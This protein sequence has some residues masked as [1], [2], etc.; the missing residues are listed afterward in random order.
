M[1]LE[2]VD[3]SWC[4]VMLNIFSCAYWPSICLFVCL[5]WK[6]IQVLCSFL[7]WVVCLVIELL[8]IF[9]YSGYGTLLRYVTLSI[10]SLTPWVVFSLFFWCCH[11]HHD[12][13]QLID[14]FSFVA[15]T[16]G[17]VS[18]KLLPNPITKRYSYMFP[19]IVFDEE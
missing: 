8:E 6:N 11:V 7:N 1:S 9:T 12:Q 17:V 16:L 13:V 2:M 18:E 14:V 15:C 5:F 10:P 19:F 3:M 4:L